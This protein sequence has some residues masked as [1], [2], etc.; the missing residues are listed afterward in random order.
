MR[1]LRGGSQSSSITSL[2]MN[3]SV[4]EGEAK[5]QAKEIV[6][7]K[8]TIDEMEIRIETQKSTLTARDESIKKLLE[9]LQNKGIT[10][11]QMEED[12][13]ENDR[14]RQAVAEEEQQRHHLQVMLEER[15]QE[16]EQLKAVSLVHLLLNKEQCCDG[17]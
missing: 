10:T 16:M 1:L 12:R 13:L 7:L 14:L 8:R 15:D 9:M 11:Q 5:R 17:T 6:I 2:N 4:N 3:N